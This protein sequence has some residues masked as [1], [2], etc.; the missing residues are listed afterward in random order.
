LFLPLIL[1]STS[2][3]RRALLERLGV[4]FRCVSPGVEEAYIAGEPP[5]ERALRLAQAKARAV[6]AR[7]PEAVVIGGDQVAAAG[8]AVLDKPGD[9]AGARAQLAV[10]SGT[11][12]SFYTAC[13]VLAPTA[14]AANPG[15]TASAEL[16]LQHLDTTTV[17]FRPLDEGEIARYVEREQPF[18][19]AGGFKVETAGIALFTRIDSTDP[20]ALVGLPLIWVADALRRAGYQVP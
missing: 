10:L 8:T 15:E 9:A 16:S 20:S 4:P 11:V 13:V 1:A 14:T 18:D 7:H 5:H 19:C 2:P 17:H 3:Y 12:A 6:Q